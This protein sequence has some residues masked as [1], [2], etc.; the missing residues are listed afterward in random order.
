MS[1][2]RIREGARL[3]DCQAREEALASAIDTPD[4]RSL[5]QT[6]DWSKS[7]LGPMDTWPSALRCAL[8]LALPSDAQIVIFWGPAFIAL[9]NDAYRPTIGQ[10]HPA[11]FGGPAKENWTELWDDLE[12]LLKTVLETGKTVSAQNRPFHIERFGYPETVYFD[13][14]YSPISASEKGALGVLCIVNE[15]TAR[16]VAQQK[17]IENQQRLELLFSQTDAGI[18]LS[19]RAGTMIKVNPR[20]CALSGH[21]EEAMLAGTLEAMLDPAD[22]AAYRASIKALFTSGESFVQRFTLI[23]ADGRHTPV[24][25]A[26]SPVRDGTGAITH[27]VWTIIDITEQLRAQHLESQLAAIVSSSHDAILSTDLNMCILS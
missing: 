9:Y 21:S 12:P 14:S 5:L 1:G 3:V 27:A 16:V 6:M 8:D 25:C 23:G 18:A 10:K 20:L 17:L 22:R 26:A 7:P 15:T 19:D 4:C 11:A 24:S 13:I 2:N